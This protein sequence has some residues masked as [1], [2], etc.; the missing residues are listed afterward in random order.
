MEHLTGI[1]DGLLDPFSS[2]WTSTE[3]TAFNDATRYKY[4]VSPTFSLD[5]KVGI[6][7]NIFSSSKASLHSLV[8]VKSFVCCIILKKGRHCSIDLEMN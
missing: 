1:I 7:R 5:S 4:K 2:T 3:L 8:Q 6:L